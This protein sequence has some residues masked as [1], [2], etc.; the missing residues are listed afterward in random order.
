MYISKN[1]IWR[2]ID[3]MNISIR[4]NKYKA[5]EILRN[6]EGINPFILRMKRDIILYQKVLSGT[7]HWRTGVIIHMSHIERNWHFIWYIQVTW[8]FWYIWY[9]LCFC[10]FQDTCSYKTV[11]IWYQRVLMWQY[12]RRSL[13]ISLILIWEQRRKI[14][15]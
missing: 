6:Y 2:N 1:E 10:L 14:R 12:S 11:R 15:K 3:S 13:Y 4:S 5:I 9:I 8:C 7:H